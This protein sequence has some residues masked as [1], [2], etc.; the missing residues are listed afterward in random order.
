[1]SIPKVRTLPNAIRELRE[2]DPNTSFSL[3]ALKRCCANGE[4]PVIR[5]ASRILVNMDAV[6]SYLE[7]AQAAPVP[8][9][10]S[11]GI[12]RIG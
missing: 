8:V 10:D 7:T 1:M 11:N 6:I 2:S 3:R 5:V 4:I 9:T 12:R